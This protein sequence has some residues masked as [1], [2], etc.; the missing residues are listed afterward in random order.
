[1]PYSKPPCHLVSRCPLHR[2]IPAR[3][4]VANARQGPAPAR[5]G[6]RVAATALAPG[7]APRNPPDAQGPDPPDLLDA[8][9]RLGVLA[10]P[11]VASVDDARAS[12]RHDVAR[13][14]EQLVVVDLRA[15]REHDE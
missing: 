10:L 9:E 4:V 12:R 11:H 3:G 5:G 2:V 7:R 13:L 6:L 15:A 1:M 14:L 8:L